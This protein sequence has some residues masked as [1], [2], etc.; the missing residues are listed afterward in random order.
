V[1]SAPDDQ[2]AGVDVGQERG[3]PEFATSVLDP[4]VVGE[5]VLDPDVV[6]EEEAAEPR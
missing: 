4:D 5:D 3:E 1:R 2:R 6:G